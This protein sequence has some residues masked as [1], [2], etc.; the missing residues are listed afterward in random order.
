[1]K[2][3]KGA[4]N[5]VFYGQHPEKEVQVPSGQE[6]KQTPVVLATIK[7]ESRPPALGL[8]SFPSLQSC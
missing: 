1:M 7:G 6:V 4:R 2:L 3:P 8:G 5:P